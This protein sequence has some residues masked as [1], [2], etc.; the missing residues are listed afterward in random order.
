M[1]KKA[2]LPG[3]TKTL[4]RDST[5]KDPDNIQRQSSIGGTLDEV[6]QLVTEQS[7]ATI[8][9]QVLIGESD[10]MD[11]AA[12]DKNLNRSMDKDSSS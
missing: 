10:E 6:K 9:K 11:E 5:L 8:A 4:T 7:T 12:E 3:E 1:V 2:K